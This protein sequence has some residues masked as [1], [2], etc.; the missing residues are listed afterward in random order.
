VKLRCALLHA[1]F[2]VGSPTAHPSDR[3]EQRAARSHS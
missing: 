2:K 1:A 3:A